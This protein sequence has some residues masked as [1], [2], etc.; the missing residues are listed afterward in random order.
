MSLVIFTRDLRTVDNLTLIEAS[1]YK[2]KIY[3]VFFIP[4]T[5][6]TNVR[7][8]EFLLGSLLDL[9]KN[10]PISIFKNFYFLKQIF[11]KVKINNVFITLD[12]TPDAE[13]R[14][15]KISSICKSSGIQFHQIQD[16]TLLPLHTVL[17]NAGKPY[18]KYTPFYRTFLKHKI[19][20][21][22]LKKINFTKLPIKGKELKG[23]TIYGRQEALKLL[24]LKNYSQENNPSGLSPYIYF[25]CVS[26]RECLKIRNIKKQLAW[27]EFYYNLY[28]KNKSIW[29]GLKKGKIT[30][31]NSN[32]NR[33]KN[34]KTGYH[35]ID[36]AMTELNIT[37]YMS[38]RLRML[39]A[40]FLIKKML[41]DWKKGEK[42]FAKKLIDYDPIL[43]NGNWQWVS[44]FGTD[45]QPY[46][47]TFSPTIQ[48]KKVDPNGTYIKKWLP[49]LK[50]VNID[51]IH[52]PSKTVKTYDIRVFI[53]KFIKSRK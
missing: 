52:N 53:S 23:P 12:P 16:L 11:Q 36:A 14:D 47:R 29:A 26:I 42:Y 41:I 22:N 1:K 39:C 35:I 44:G 40:D 37:G 32:F 10:C 51:E 33:W 13:S 30:W 20:K 25:G 38:N 45:S 28:Y 18:Q 27:R 2:D 7:T 9:K 46:F 48:S 34:G 31:S 4:Q 19:Q 17:N 5:A 8:E 43:N 49:K 3:P 15:K 6:G 24:K 21:P 50:N